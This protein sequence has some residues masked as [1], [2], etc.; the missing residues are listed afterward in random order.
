MVWI[1]NE[2]Y[3]AKSYPPGAYGGAI[4]MCARCQK[5]RE[6]VARLNKERNHLQEVLIRMADALT[7]DNKCA[8]GPWQDDVAND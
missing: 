1:N 2:H 8:G 6:D 3:N 4:C 7:D 5:S